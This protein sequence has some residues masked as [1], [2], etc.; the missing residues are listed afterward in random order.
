MIRPARHSDATRVIGLLRDS[1]VAAGFDRADGPSGFTFPFEAADAEML[2]FSHLVTPRSFA[3]VHD[4]DGTAQGVLLAMAF[5]HKFGKV[6]LANETVWFID[7]G[8]RGS[9]APR[10][11]DAYEAWAFN[12]QRCGFAGMAGM[13]EDPE[14]AKLYL[15]RGYRAVEK[16]FL[17]VL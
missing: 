12:E 9:A 4:V 15:R 14:V 13:G 17:K 8:H 16:H 1:H 5:K 10:M 3:I 7:A 11:L 2:F 6:W